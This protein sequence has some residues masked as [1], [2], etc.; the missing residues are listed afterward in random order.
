P[1]SKATEEEMK[2]LQDAGTISLVRINKG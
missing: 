2:A 1:I